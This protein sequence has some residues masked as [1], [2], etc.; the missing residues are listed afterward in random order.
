MRSVQRAATV[1]WVLATASAAAAPLLTRSLTLQPPADPAHELPVSAGSWAD[2]SVKM[3]FVESREAPVVADRINTSLFV[4][5]MS[6]PAPVRPGPRF[7]L[8]AEQLP[9]GTASQDVEFTRNDGLVLTVRITAEGC[10]AYCET[11]EQDYSFDARNGRALALE[12]LLTP[13]GL[14]ALMAHMGRTR[15]QAY[16]S[17]LKTLKQE[18][19]AA[20]RRGGAKDELDDLEDRIALNQGC[21]DGEKTSARPVDDL[22]YASFSLPPGQGLRLT[23][24]RCSN[25]ASR[26]LDDVGNVKV[27]VP[28]AQLRPWLN[29]YGLAV[30][31][32]EG[33]GP[34]P[35]EPFGQVLHGRIGT[36]P[37]TVALD[38]LYANGSVSGHYWYDKYGRLIALSGRRQGAQLTLTEGE[39]PQTATITLTWRGSGFSG[40]W[41]GDGKTLPVQLGW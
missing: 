5:L 15:Q 18:L 1:L 24:G 32:S 3:P 16:A 21:M 17:Q 7:T 29:A 39:A 36:A 34:P 27:E 13:R 11:Y 20:R 33:D 31:L 8:P 14:A 10:G 9:Q 38:R 25:H 12:D 19:T 26:A 28:A 30:V 35:S 2:G 41:Q 23:T 40:P 6:A 4:A 37:V 22:R